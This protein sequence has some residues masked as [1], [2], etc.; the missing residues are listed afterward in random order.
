MRKLRV[1]ESEIYRAEHGFGR[2][3]EG[4]GGFGLALGWARRF[5]GMAWNWVRVGRGMVFAP[6]EV[7]LSVRDRVLEVARPP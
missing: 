6:W 1:V 2:W 7:S 4:F 3:V 5:R